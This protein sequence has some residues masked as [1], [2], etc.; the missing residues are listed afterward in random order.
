MATSSELTPFWSR[1]HKFFLW[2]AQL[3][4]LVHVTFLSLLAIPGHYL[5]L[6]GFAIDLVA[7]YLFFKYATTMLVETSR[8]NLDAESV[9][10]ALQQ[11]D[12]RA[13]KQGVCMVGGIL[14]AVLIAGTFGP[15]PALLFALI[16][17]LVLPAMIIIIAIHDSLLEA[18][19]PARLVEI[20]QG[21]GAPYL[22]MCFFLLLLQ[23]AAAAILKMLGPRIPV[24][25]GVPL[26]SFVSMYM[27]LAMYHMIGYVVYQYHERLG[28]GVDKSFSENE[29]VPE[30]V[31]ADSGNGVGALMG[32]G[33]IEGAIAMLEERLRASP[34]D[35]DLHRKLGNLL[36]A[37]GDPV[38]QAEHARRFISMLRAERKT[39]L[40]YDVFCRMRRTA[41]DFSIDSADDI[42][43]LANE[44]K[45][46]G[47]PALAAEMIRG[48]DKK[49][50]SHPDVAGVYLL[51]ARIAS[52]VRHDDAQAVNLLKAL[53]ARFPEAPVAAEAR[54]LLQVLMAMSP[55]AD[56][57]AAT[58]EG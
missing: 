32:Q 58:A 24:W 28:Y 17:A 4:P 42:L 51:A 31:S 21:I 2:P 11:K 25:L 41:A 36:L 45:L 3:G 33:D 22:L 44:A 26:A 52:D 16:F 18:V 27:L 54:S 5:P 46:R 53:L 6:V 49:H 1:I 7:G 23:I 8:G 50:A 55:A 15:V 37:H 39:D 43:P 57:R 20:V 35:V 12:Y 10:M 19:Q 29:G 9:D 13:I 30:A 56:A 40:A 34:R 14:L 38:R 48:F 47:N